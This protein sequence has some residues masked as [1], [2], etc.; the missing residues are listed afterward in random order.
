MANAQNQDFSLLS[1]SEIDTLINF[2][3]DK[4]EGVDSSVLNQESIDKL[5]EM[6]RFNNGRAKKE[7][8][9][10][11]GEVEGTL[12]DLITVR[13]GDD[14]CVLEYSV[15]EANDFVRLEAVNTVTKERMEI[16]PKM[17]NEGDGEL[18]GHC[19]APLVL[20]RMARALKVKYTAETYENLCKRYA[21]YIYGDAS[22]KL[23]FL[24]MPGN[25]ENIGN[26]L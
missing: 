18:W 11:M 17:F 20:H 15:D 8:I 21:K 12:A 14:V 5:L 7:E 9:L 3:N 13:H 23:P 26:I 24:F 22:R 4:R 19:I 2:I 16:T 1:Q 25:R 10:H 6:L